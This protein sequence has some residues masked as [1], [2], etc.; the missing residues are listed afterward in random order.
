MRTYA[1]DVAS[2]PVSSEESPLAIS[3]ESFARKRQIPI[4]E[5]KPHGHVFGLLS[6]LELRKP[7]LLGA[8][9]LASHPKLLA[10]LA[11]EGGIVGMVH[12]I[13]SPRIGE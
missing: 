5:E 3:R 6:L 8:V 12:S 2:D 10:S 4:L 11:H 1:G 9:H 7:R 13:V